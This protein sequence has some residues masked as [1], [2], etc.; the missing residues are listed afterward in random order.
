MTVRGKRTKKEATDVASP[1]GGQKR[2]DQGIKE[3]KKVVA[4]LEELFG[5]S[6]QLEVEPKIKIYAKK[7]LH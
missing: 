3:M 5:I 6:V 4:K 1:R 7:K 2:Q